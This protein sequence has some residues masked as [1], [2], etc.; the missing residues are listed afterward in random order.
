MLTVQFPSL[1]QETALHMAK[2]EHHK[3]TELCLVERGADVSIKDV[4][5][6]D[7]VLGECGA[8]W[9]LPDKVT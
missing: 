5:G 6:R 8:L 3:K 2:K 4:S 7:Y 1:H 9:S